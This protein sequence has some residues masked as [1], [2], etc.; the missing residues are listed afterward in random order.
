MENR[1]SFTEVTTEGWGSR[2]MG[3]IKSILFGIVLFIVA[4]V[5]LWLNEERA[6]DTAKG[7]TEGASQVISINSQEFRNENSG[8]LVHITGNI[9]S[10]ETLKDEE[11]NVNVNA[12]KLQRKVEMYQWIEKKDQEK[13]KELGGSEKTTTVYNYV[14]EWE[15]SIIKSNDFKHTEGHSNPTS[16][17]YSEYTQTVS[18][19][20]MGEFNISSYLLASMNSYVPFS[21]NSVD[22][23][24]YPNARITNEGNANIGTNT[25]LIKKIF[26][27]KGSS[28]SPQ[29]GDVKVWFEIVKSGDE[30][31][32]ISQQI[33]NTFEP[34]STSTGTSIQII[35]KGIQ[36][37]ESMFNAAQKSNTIVTWLLKLLG[38][39]L[40]FA[41]LS[42]IVK[43]L[44]VLADV[45]P[46]LGTILNFGLSLFT[47]L[48]SFALSFITIAIA[49][50]VF[51]PILGISLLAIGIGIALFFFIR[52]PKNKM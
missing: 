22:S 36:S 30:Y 26:I 35:S 45:V 7:L 19:A 50:I 46:F 31:S 48:L 3:S 29:V 18:K 10:K 24:K 8:K 2:I 14:K 39:L 51:R 33:G 43:P 47:G 32:I 34:Y 16:F 37:A 21:I 42:L 38:F 15:E 13:E 40:L 52:K 20:S 12:L 27:G 44:V 1:D 25:N 49:W 6:V 11:F 17:P 5:V 28:S 41:G 23:I 4:F 9:L